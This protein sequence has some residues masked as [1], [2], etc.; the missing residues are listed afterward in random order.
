MKDTTMASSPETTL[1]HQGGLARKLSLFLAALALTATSLV[2]AAVDEAARA[3]LPEDIKQKGTLVV[4]MP[5]DFEP[6][7]WLDEKNQPT[8]VDVEMIRAIGDRL[9]LK[10]D[11]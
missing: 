9:G 1:R 7:N 4:A 2:H 11:I 8:G 10:V 3:L 5:L 6:F